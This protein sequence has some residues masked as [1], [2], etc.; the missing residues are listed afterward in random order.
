MSALMQITFD[1]GAKVRDL[2]DGEYA[3]LQNAMPKIFNAPRDEWH[4]GYEEF[5]IDD[6]DASLLSNFDIEFKIKKFKGQMKV[7]V[8]GA[9]SS[10]A[11]TVHV[12]VPNVGLLSMTEVTWIEDACTE[13]LQRKLD[14]GWRILCVCPPNNQRRP[15]Y[16]LGRAKPDVN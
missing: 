15:D 2:T 16:I 14:D 3:R 9:P 6:E 11:Q 12:H 8:P 5:L 1:Y 4:G 7:A 10:D 13:D